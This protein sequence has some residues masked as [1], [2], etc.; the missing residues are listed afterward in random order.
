MA[1]KELFK[2]EDVLNLLDLT[3]ER[4]LDGVPMVSVPVA[5]MAKEYLDKHETVEE[6][7]CDMMDKQILKCT[8][9]GMITGFGGLL[10]LPVA[11]PANVSSVLYVQMRMI[12]CAAQMA[13]YDLDS[14]QTKTFVYACLAGISLNQMI[15]KTS[16]V[17][18]QKVATKMI[19]RIPGRLLTAINRRVGFRLVTKFGSRGVVNLGKL[20]PGV[21]GVISGGFDYMETKI[22]ADRT[23]HW[24]F[25]GDF[26][27]KDK[28]EEWLEEDFAEK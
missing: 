2:E 1:K 18:G 17:A 28:E 7:V 8:T 5:Q 25:Q 15:K 19:A 4:V 14:D 9:S 27:T 20:V 13:G 26:S 23:Y 10:T 24:F 3:Y 6:A 22:I 16:I 12:A 21:G 11:V